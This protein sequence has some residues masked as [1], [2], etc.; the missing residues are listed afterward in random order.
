[1]HGKKS[2][3]RSK[4]I[5]LILLGHGSKLPDY[6]RVVE[7]HRERIE[8]FGIFDEVRTAYIMEEPRLM[9]VLSEMESD[10]I[11][12]VPLFISYG[13]HLREIEEIVRGDGRV[14]LCKPI[15]ESELLTYA[16]VLSAL[17]QKTF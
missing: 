3:L 11:F 4:M 14:R 8:E 6:R 17:I 13:E 7:R 1:M 10:V 15:G 5:G 16:I 9:E 12:V 2:I